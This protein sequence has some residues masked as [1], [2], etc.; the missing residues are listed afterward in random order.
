MPQDPEHQLPFS[1]GEMR[2][3]PSYLPNCLV[4]QRFH[5]LVIEGWLASV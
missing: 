5:E 4:L 1:L 3:I 2:D